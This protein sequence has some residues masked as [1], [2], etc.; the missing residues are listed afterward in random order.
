MLT[1]TKIPQGLQK[2]DLVVKAIEEDKSYVI[3]ISVVVDNTEDV[4]IP[5]Q[6]KVDYYNQQDDAV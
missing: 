1:C 4:D 6:R 5:R 2:P 3:H